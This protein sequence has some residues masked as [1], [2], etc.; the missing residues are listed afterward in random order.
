MV[1]AGACTDVPVEGK[2]FVSYVIFPYGTIPSPVHPFGSVDRHFVPVIFYSP[3]LK[4]GDAN[5][6]CGRIITLVSHYVKT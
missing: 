2:V 1:I 5:N 6:K 4:L 3:L